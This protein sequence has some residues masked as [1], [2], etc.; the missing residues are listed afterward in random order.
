RTVADCL[1]G[2]AS[3][4]GVLVICGKGNNGGDG[5]AAARL[6]ATAGARVDVVLMGIVDDTK[7]DARQNFERL[8]SWND[9]QTD[10]GGVVNLFECNSEKGWQQ[11]VESVLSTSH[12]AVVDALFGT[13]LTRE[14]EGLYLEPIKY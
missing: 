7:G 9:N 10:A 3:G 8:Q 2:N 1:A 13:G 5:V 11:L 4:K 6:L 12:D 14:I